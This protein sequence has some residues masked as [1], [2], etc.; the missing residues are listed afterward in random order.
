MGVVIAHALTGSIGE[1]D[2]G[3]SAVEASG[4]E[5]DDGGREEHA[6]SLAPAAEVLAPC[7]PR[8][9][10]GARVRAGVVADP[11]RLLRPVSAGT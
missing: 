10:R 2:I 11:A 9:A 3:E 1:H 7:G 5:D 6:R 4:S 8:T